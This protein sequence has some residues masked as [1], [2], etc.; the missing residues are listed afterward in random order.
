MKSSVVYAVT[1]HTFVRFESIWTRGKT[2]W[3][4]FSYPIGCKKNALCLEFIL[5]NSKHDDTG[6]KLKLKVIPFF[7]AAHRLLRITLRHPR[8]RQFF[9]LSRKE[10]T[11]AAAVCRAKAF[12]RHNSA[13]DRLT[14]SWFA[15]EKQENERIARVPEVCSGFPLRGRRVVELLKCPSWG[16][17]LWDLWSLWDSSTAL[18]LH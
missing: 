13:A 10:Q 3:R 18:Q 4:I 8:W 14:A 12:I 16:F 11:R 6:L 1:L 9:P 17:G 7:C 2:F 15:I 5:K